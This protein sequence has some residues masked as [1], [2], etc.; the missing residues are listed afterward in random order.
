MLLTRRILDADR[1]ILRCPKSSFRDTPPSCN[2][3][4]LES[5]WPKRPK[6]TGRW[7]LRKS[8]GATMRTSLRGRREYHGML[9]DG[10]LILVR[11]LPFALAAHLTW[12]LVRRFA[13]RPGFR[14]CLFGA[15]IKTLS[16]RS[17]LTLLGH[18]LP[19]M[20]GK[21]SVALPAKKQI[22]VPRA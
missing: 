22:F 7:W 15:L 16:E 1:S 17:K 20:P 4:H 3:L 5:S 9:L 21:T 18:Y 8:G 13:F 10:T 11:H 19:T 6:R 2:H 14:F 12:A